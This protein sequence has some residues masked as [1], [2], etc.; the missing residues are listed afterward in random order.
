MRGRKPAGELTN[1]E[2]VVLALY[3]SPGRRD[4]AHPDE[5]AE[6]LSKA[7]ITQLAG[8][9]VRARLTELRHEGLVWPVGTPTGFWE[10][11]AKGVTAA[12]ELAASLGDEELGRYAP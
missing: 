5:V 4:G 12:E 11:T 9:Q 10:L 8:G 2:H 7:G 1:R 3:S 6:R